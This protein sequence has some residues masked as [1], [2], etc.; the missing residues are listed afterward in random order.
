MARVSFGS[1]AGGAHDYNNGQSIFTY[2]AS[3][4]NGLYETLQ[5]LT[6][7][8]RNEIEACAESEVPELST[9]ELAIHEN[10]VVPL[11]RPTIGP[12][13]DGGQHDLPTDF[14]TEWTDGSE[15]FPGLSSALPKASIAAILGA[16]EGQ[17]RQIVQ[18]AA[19]RAIVQCIEAVDGFKYSFNNA[20]NAKDEGGLRFSYICQDSMQ[21]KDRHA[22]GFTKTQKHLKGEG[23]RGPRKPTYDCKGS[24]SVKFSLI[25]SR[26]DVYYRHYAVHPSVADRRPAPRP[27]PRQRTSQSEDDFNYLPVA[28]PEPD[29]GGL[30]GQL[31]DQSTAYE[32]PARMAPPTAPQRTPATKSLK[33]KREVE[34][35]PQ[36]SSKPLSLFELL[37]QSETAKIPDA[38]PNSNSKTHAIPPPVEYNLPSWQA[39]PPIQASSYRPPGHE[40]YS[41]NAPYPP[42]YQ[43]Q[44]YQNQP[45]IATPKAPVAIPRQGSKPSGLQNHYSN[46]QAY[47]GAPPAGKATH[48]QSQGLFS[49][50]KPVAKTNYPAQ[51]HTHF[52]VYASTGPQRAKTSCSNCRISKKKVRSDAHS[53]ILEEVDLSSPDGAQANGSYPLQC[54]EARPNCGNCVRSGKSGCVYEGSQAGPATEYNPAQQAQAMGAMQQRQSKVVSQSPA[55][56]PTTAAAG[57]VVAG[58]SQSPSQHQGHRGPNVTTPAYP[59]AT[60]YGKS[61]QAIVNSQQQSYQTAASH[62]SYGSAKSSQTFAGASQAQSGKQPSPDP[63]FPSR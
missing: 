41:P 35:S 8:L 18:R 2:R 7:A 14:K 4:A 47:L 45:P 61:T 54:D 17:A 1:R 56:A 53:Y 21:N 25:R 59:Q 19:S 63:W 57:G 24:V 42:P 39:P 26:V 44:R 46:P 22:N 5:D 20:W 29:T 58:P 6:A 28:A 16:G 50:L 40:N 27:P 34:Q 36:S 11:L 38:T 10:A 30:L 32:G 3:Q 62:Q 9:C 49:T 51:Q 31:R 43:P 37:Q 60:A 48:P 23:E 13:A 52:I 12:Y 55:P 15:G 33:R